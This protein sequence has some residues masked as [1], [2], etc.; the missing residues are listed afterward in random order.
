MSSSILVA[1]V[2][3]KTAPIS[4]LERLAIN[5]ERLPK[6][7]HELGGAEH[8]LEC[9][10]L[11]TCNRIEVY[12]LVS[13][14]HAGTQDVRNFLSEFCHVAPE[15]FVDSLYTY[16]DE[17]AVKHLFRVAAGVDSMVV[18]ESEILGQVR[19]SFQSAADEGMVQRVLGAAFRQ[20]LRVGKR[21][22]TETAI[23]RNPVSV[24]SAAVDLA[25]RAFDDGSLDGKRI[26][27]V[28]A[29]KM[30]R[31]AARALSQAGAAE[32]TVVNRT[33]ERADELAELFDADSKPFSDL[34]SVLAGSDIVISS[35]TSPEAVLDAPTVAAAM[36]QRPDRPLFIVDI[37]VPRDVDPDAADVPG[38][39]LRDI[40]DLGSVVQ[41]N[42]G[43]RLE[44]VSSVEEIITREI[45][46][47]MSWERSTEFA[48]TAAELVA[49]A[50]LLRDV[51]ME[52]IKKHLA[53]MTPEQREAV[54]HLSRRLVS[55]VLHTPLARVKSLSNSKQGH[56]Y[57]AVLRELFELDSEPGAP[58]DPSVTHR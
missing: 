28:G 51:E 38:V 4:L 56:L 57:L 35:T 2:N 24:S 47:F 54:D 43:S 36:A 46:H 7:L 18:G 44:E 29:G 41:N 34:A 48:P 13:K 40:D 52:R 23:G 14:F 12:A 10:I 3:H 27:I 32:L 20:A 21:A 1:G 45:E 5:D 31:L 9:V 15:E 22:R 39:I 17:G 50:D 25:R 37:A 8:V 33:A 6:A 55:K 30:G 11:S 58:D 19:R 26:A 49:K 16:H 42:K 53:A